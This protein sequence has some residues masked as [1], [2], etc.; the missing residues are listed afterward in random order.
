MTQEQYDDKKCPN[1]ELPIIITHNSWKKKNPETGEIEDIILRYPNLLSKD[2]HPKKLSMPCCGTKD[3]K[4]KIKIDK[5]TKKY[6]V[7]DISLPA[8][9]DRY[10]MLPIKL[11]NIIGKIVMIWQINLQIVLLEKELKV[12]NNILYQH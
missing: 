5:I 7:K 6:I 9:V 10:A 11:S 3:E 4:K 1:K 8:P 2:L 12:V